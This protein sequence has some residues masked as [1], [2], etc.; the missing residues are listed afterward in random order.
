MIKARVQ[1]GEAASARLEGEAVVTTRAA[2][3]DANRFRTRL[4]L[5]APSGGA[6]GPPGQSLIGARVEATGTEAAPSESPPVPDDLTRIRG[7]SSE[8]AVALAAEGYATFVAISAWRP[9]DV[10]RMRRFLGLKREISKQNWIEQAA[11]LV[12]GGPQ[13]P[14]P[15]GSIWDQPAPATAAAAPRVTAVAVQAP[16]LV[17]AAGSLEPALP[18]VERSSLDRVDLIRGLGPAAEELLRAGGVTSASDIARWTSADVMAWSMRLGAGKRLSS[19]GWIEQAALLARGEPT[20]HARMAILLPEIETIEAPAA[21]AGGNGVEAPLLVKL[22]ATRIAAALRRP[23]E[24]VPVFD[25]VPASVAVVVGAGATEPHH[26]SASPSPPVV[27]EPRRRLPRYIEFVRSPF[28]DLPPLPLTPLADAGLDPAPLAVAAVEPSA[29]PAATEPAS[30]P[31]APAPDVDTR[32]RTARLRPGSLVPRRARIDPPRAVL[33]PTKRLTER[34][35]ELEDGALGHPAGPSERASL[36]PV[37]ETEV[38]RADVPLDLAWLETLGDDLRV[39]AATEAEVVIVP[40]SEPVAAAAPS[41]PKPSGPSVRELRR[42]SQSASTSAD[43]HSYAG[44]RDRVEEASVEI[45]RPAGSKTR[46][47]PLRGLPAASDPGTLDR[48]LSA[49]GVGPKDGSRQ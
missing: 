11:L 48:F 39:P 14:T 20:C 35:A 45:V 36:D 9:V 17:Q 47:R 1:D 32:E 21:I 19:A 41:R 22:A 46:L 10:K 34:I 2:A 29:P 15:M 37:P 5:K 38:R 6:Q 49:L 26:G 27:A 7:I 12:A 42:Q 3:T 33:S 44:Y 16:R 23:A 30:Q 18:E 43:T 28:F 25:T 24:P 4:K 31:T 40:S 8:Q 13:R